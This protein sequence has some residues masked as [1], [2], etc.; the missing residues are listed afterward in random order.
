MVSQKEIDKLRREGNQ[1]IDSFI[2]K[3]KEDM[4]KKIVAIFLAG[5]AITKKTLGSKKDVDITERQKKVFTDLIGES[6]KG[7]SDDYKRELNTSLNI[8]L[9]QSET[10][11]QLQNRVDEILR[12]SN[13]TKMKYE[14]RLD[15]IIRTESSRIFNAG[16]L[17]TA[18]QVGAKY[19][20]LIGVNDNRQGKDSKVAINKYG[21]PEKAIPIDEDFVVREGGKTYKYL[22]PPNRPNDRS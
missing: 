18:K 16:A 3:N 10:K 15:L 4:L 19:K 20:Y 7:V 12:G 13:P 21:S 14:K 22:F 1:K 6:I 5:V 11:S 17:R 2:D 8:G 9:A